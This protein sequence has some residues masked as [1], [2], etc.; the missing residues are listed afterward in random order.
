MFLVVF[1]SFQDRDI[2]ARIRGIRGVVGIVS[3]EL[4]EEVRSK[5][6][7][8]AQSRDLRVVVEVDLFRG[9]EIN[10]G[11]MVIGD[12]EIF[13][14]RLSKGIARFSLLC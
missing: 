6:H 5:L 2:L 13:P 7:R 8:G 3:R 9:F 11:V 14:P 10:F 1:H 12:D 4:R